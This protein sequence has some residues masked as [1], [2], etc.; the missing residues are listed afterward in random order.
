MKEPVSKR[1]PFPCG[2]GG[3]GGAVVV[4]GAAEEDGANVDVIIGDGMTD[5]LAIDELV[6]DEE[7]MFTAVVAFIDMEGHSNDDEIVEFTV[8]DVFETDAEVMSTVNE[9]LETVET[10]ESIAK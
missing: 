10:D 9:K 4:V 6:T 3:R 8:D 7:D 5:E 1:F 2:F